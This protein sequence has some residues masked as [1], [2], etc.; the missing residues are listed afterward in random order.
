MYNRNVVLLKF[1]KKYILH[2]CVEHF[3]YYHN[4]TRLLNNVFIVCRRR[5]CSCFKRV[6]YISRENKTKNP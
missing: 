4:W 1:L 6:D 2:E 5:Y 3:N